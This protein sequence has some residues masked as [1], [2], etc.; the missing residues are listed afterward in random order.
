MAPARAPA[1]APAAA[2][3]PLT[4]DAV[5]ADPR[6]KIM[7]QFS[8]PKDIKCSVSK[9]YW[10]GIQGL[11]EQVHGSIM[12]WVKK[13][14]YIIKVNWTEADGSQACDTE[15]LDQLLLPE[16]DFKLIKGPRGEALHLR[17]AA[18]REAEAQ[19]PKETV[20]IKYLDGI[21]EKE[22]VWTVEPNPECIVK[23]ARTEPRFKPR[24]AR[25]VASIDTPFKAWYN[26][27]APLEMFVKMEMYFN[28]RLDGAQRMQ[29][30]RRLEASWSVFAA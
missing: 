22:Q 24:L 20:V 3:E 4:P 16:Y 15:R 25:R 27:A 6:Y 21:I 17:G 1:A 10:P 11:P 2:V 30:A 9:A 7:A 8:T 29:L 28:Q 19:Q 23:D 5:R 18:A 13:D 12:Q 26:S 14:Q